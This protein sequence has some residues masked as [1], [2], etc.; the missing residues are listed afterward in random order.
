MAWTNSLYAIPGIETDEDLS[1]S[2]FRFVRVTGANQ[3]GVIAA[4]TQAPIGVLQNAP[5]GS[6]SSIGANIMAIG[7]TKLVVGAGDLTA[8]QEV[9]IDANGLGINAGANTRVYGIC[10]ES[11]DAGEI[12]TVFVNCGSRRIPA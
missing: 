12:A 3:V 10:L 1:G 5:D 9:T 8:G 6:T 2:Q 7:V 4:D 11:A